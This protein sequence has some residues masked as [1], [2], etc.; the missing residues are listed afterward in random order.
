GVVQARRVVAGRQ[1]AALAGE[2][3]ALRA[4]EPEQL[5]ALAELAAAQRP[6]RHHRAAAD[7]LHVRRDLVDLLLGVRRPRWRRLFA[8]CLPGLLQPRRLARLLGDLTAG[9]NPAGGPL[10]VHRILADTPHT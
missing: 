9:R 7:G 1:R 2:V 3:V 6:G 4:V 10:E 8:G 5:A